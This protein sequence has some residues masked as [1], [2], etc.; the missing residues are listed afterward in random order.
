MIAKTLSAR[1]RICAPL[2]LGIFVAWLALMPKPAAAQATEGLSGQPDAANT[3]NALA[4]AKRRGLTFCYGDYALCAA[5]T[6]TPTGRK[7]KVKG[8]KFPAASCECP[9]LNGWNIADLSGGNMNGSCDPPPNGVWS[10]YFPLTEV[11]QEN[12]VPAWQTESATPLSCP[13]G[14]AREFAECFSF[15]CVLDGSV[16]GQALAK[17]TCPIEKAPKQW[18][19]AGGNCDTS[20]CSAEM[21]VGAPF[22]TEI[23]ACSN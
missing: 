17:C 2:F 1:A 7:I 12:T 5:A 20:N 18:V 3:L 22:P 6:C 8:K 19:T 9:I 10:T 15:S 13:G 21:L 16:N 4:L 23:D 11:P 14:K